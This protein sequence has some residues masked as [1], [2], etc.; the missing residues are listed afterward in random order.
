MGGDT[1]SIDDFTKNF[2]LCFITVVKDSLYATASHVVNEDSEEEFEIR[3][4][5]PTVDHPLVYAP[6]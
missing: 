6:S 3:M 1:G 4:E 5:G 2:L